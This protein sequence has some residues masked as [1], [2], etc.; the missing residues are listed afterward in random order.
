[1]TDEPVARLLRWALNHLERRTPYVW[2]GKDPSTGLDCSGF[3]TEGLFHVGGPDWRKTHNT[4]RLWAECQRIELD[5]VRPGDAVLYWGAHSTGPRDVSHVM[6][7]LDWGLVIGQAYGGTNNVSAEY[8]R[9]LGHWTKIL[10][11]RY[12][13]DV[14]GAVRLPLPVAPP[15]AAPKGLT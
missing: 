13:S 3:V 5:Q 7:A 1:M 11:L 9:A 12:R 8:S 4:D 2:A 14:A 6:L 15:P 10:P